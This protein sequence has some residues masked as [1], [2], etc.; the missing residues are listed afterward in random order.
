M[1]IQATIEGYPELTNDQKER[2]LFYLERQGPTAYG[3]EL[4][5]AIL[6]HSVI[7]EETK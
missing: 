7:K 6:G 3:I 4:A 2:L 5:L 1:K